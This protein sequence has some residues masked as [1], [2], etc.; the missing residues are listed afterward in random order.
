[1]PKDIQSL[2]IQTHILIVSQI[3]SEILGYRAPIPSEQD[4]PPKF[5]YM[6]IY[7][8]KMQDEFLEHYPEDVIHK[9][10]KCV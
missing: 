6:L 10:L 4:D 7:C 1:M 3:K 9:S 8:Q 2:N 5:D